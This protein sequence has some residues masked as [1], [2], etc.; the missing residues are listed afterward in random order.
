MSNS[1]RPTLEFAPGQSP[2]ADYFI[3]KLQPYK[4][5]ISAVPFLLFVIESL[6]ASCCH[7]TYAHTDPFL[8]L[9]FAQLLAVN[10]VL[11]GLLHFFSPMY[12]FYTS[13]IFL[14]FKNFWLY[15]SGI[16][17]ILA[18][19]GLTFDVTQ[20]VA[21]KCMVA[22]LIL[23]FPANVACVVMEHPKQVVF[24]GSTVKAL[25]RLPIQLPF[26]FWAWWFT[27]AAP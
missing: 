10:S 5:F 16:V 1:K 13:M 9:I 8:K 3:R 6:V 15:A 21:A 20:V 12:H 25:L 17:L 14:P 23:M 18:G 24:G 2:S 19:L 4:S 11:A 26:I 22:I 7:Y 27:N